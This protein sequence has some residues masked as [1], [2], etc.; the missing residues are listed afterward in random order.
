MSKVELIE[1]MAKRLVQERTMLSTEEFTTLIQN[2]E[3][4]DEKAL[5]AD[6]Y[7]FLLALRQKDVMANEKY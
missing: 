5:Y 1:K 6:I 2:A 7:N 3:S 4:E